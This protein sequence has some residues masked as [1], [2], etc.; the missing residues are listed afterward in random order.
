Y[1]RSRGFGVPSVQIDGNDVIAGF[2]AGSYWLDQARNG[3]GPAMIESK[4]FRMGAHTSSDDPTRYQAAELLSSWQEKDPIQRLETY[5]RSQGTPEEFFS[6]AAT[7]AADVASDMRKRTLELQAP[8][9]AE[10]FRNVYAE[11]HPVMIEQEQWL[12]AYE[13]AFGEEL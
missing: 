12:A 4:T 11:E 3:H 5:L 8:S 10:I 6:E 2:L 7:H 9:V 13:K 1:L